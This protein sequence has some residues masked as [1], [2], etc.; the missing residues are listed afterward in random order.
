MYPSQL[1]ILQRR[2]EALMEQQVGFCCPFKELTLAGVFLCARLIHFPDTRLVGRHDESALRRRSSPY[3][4]LK[5]FALPCQV[6]LA[7]LAAAEH[8]GESARAS[9]RFSWPLD[10]VVSP[11]FLLLAR[12]QVRWR[13]RPARAGAA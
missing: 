1:P 5:R 12:V 13:P 3:L 6:V 7:S 2:I 9:R 4:V 10:R 8:T 11:C